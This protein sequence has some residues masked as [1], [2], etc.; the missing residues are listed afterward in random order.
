MRNKINLFTNI[1]DKEEG[2]SVYTQNSY[3]IFSWI[4]ADES[5]INKRYH[6][7]NYNIINK[8]MIDLVIICRKD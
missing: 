8:K 4:G 7:T 2:W 3:I 1:Y 6:S 5:H